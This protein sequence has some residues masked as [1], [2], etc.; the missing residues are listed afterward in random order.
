MRL[1]AWGAGA[2]A[3]AAQT[4]SSPRRGTGF[5]KLFKEKKDLKYFG[6]VKSEQEKT[7]IIYLHFAI[8]FSGPGS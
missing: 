5:S 6:G 7:L 4:H 1:A 3:A 8:S 2:A